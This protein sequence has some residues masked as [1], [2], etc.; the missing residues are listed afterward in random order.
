MSNRLAHVY[1][2]TTTTPVNCLFSRTTLVSQ[3][4][5][6]KASLDLSEAR[7]DE[8]FGIQWHLM[9]DMKTICTL[10][11]AGNYTSNASLNF[12][13]PDAL[14]DAQQCPS[15]EGQ[16]HVCL[17]KWPLN[18]MWCVCKYAYLSFF[19]CEWFAVDAVDD[20]MCLGTLYTKR[21]SRTQVYAGR[22]VHYLTGL[23]LN[24]FSFSMY[25]YVIAC[26]YVHCTICMCA[27][28][29]YAYAAHPMGH[30]GICCQLVHLCVCVC[31]RACVR[32][33]HISI[34]L[35]FVIIMCLQCF[36]AVG[37]AAGRASGL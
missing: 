36:D 13:R 12:Y 9:D 29:Y 5:K 30:S 3:Y 22:K 14:S 16:C 23:C 21:N 37:W 26:I 27:F 15:T 24:I 18:W 7:D 35:S 33:V 1:L 8:V 4:Q 31:V 28:I 32:V 2:K 19:L 34:Y 25:V 6:G 17:K 10:L 11:Q 20:D